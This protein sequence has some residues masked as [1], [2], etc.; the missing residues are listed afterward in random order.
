M[1]TDTVLEEEKDYDEEDIQGGI[2][3]FGIC[4]GE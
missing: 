4:F 1:S 3:F 2:T